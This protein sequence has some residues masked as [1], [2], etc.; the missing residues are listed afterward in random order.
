MEAAG[1][2]HVAEHLGMPSDQGIHATPFAAATVAAAA[3][4]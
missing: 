4:E 2:A 3:A 1:E